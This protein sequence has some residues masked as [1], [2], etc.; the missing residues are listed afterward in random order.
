MGTVE[1]KI[2][3]KTRFNELK[4]T[5]SVSIDNG[6]WHVLLEQQVSTHEL[7]SVVQASDVRDVCQHHPENIKTLLVVLA[8]AL[9]HLAAPQAIA[10][11]N[12]HISSV[13]K[14]ATRVLPV[15]YEE[16]WG[17][18]YIWLEQGTLGEASPHKTLG[19]AF[20][21]SGKRLFLVPEFSHSREQSR[22]HQEACAVLLRFL[23]VLLSEQIYG[24]EPN[25]LDALVAIPD[26]FD[27]LMTI[28]L[29][30]SLWGPL[31]QVV[32]ALDG[33]NAGLSI[34]LLDL[35]VIHVPRNG[36]NQFRK[37]LSRITDANASKIISKISNPSVPVLSLIWELLQANSEVRKLAA[38]TKLFSEQLLRLAL[39]LPSAPNPEEPRLA[40][41]ILL[42]LSVEPEF[43][44]LWATHIVNNLCIPSYVSRTKPLEPL[45]ML[46]FNLM[47][48]VDANT[49]PGLI[50]FVQAALRTGSDE[51]ELGIV[52][53][54]FLMARQ[55]ENAEKIAEHF[56]DVGSERESLTPLDIEFEPLPF[57]WTSTRLKWYMSLIWGDLYSRETEP[58]GVGPWSGTNVKFFKV[59][60]EHR[61]GVVE[62]AAGAAAGAASAAAADIWSWANRWRSE[63]R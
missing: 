19:E 5:P 56:S 59:T 47:P 8:R 53:L 38:K 42:T 2:A 30:S 33:Y 15:V 35:A 27:S 36:V 40:F 58:P 45:L 63:Y 60:K 54:R 29:A 51:A 57:N 25:G 43:C 62:A 13:L 6:L 10:P 37:R 17:R 52:S 4:T 26:I 31:Q 14:Y 24:G 55:P 23:L 16:C 3:V 9:T 49:I 32:G 41:Y 44:A 1:S 50:A 34:Y 22:V 46:C 20:L 18:T 21:F 7:Y 12:S 11:G 48:Y 39:K 28:A 61:Q